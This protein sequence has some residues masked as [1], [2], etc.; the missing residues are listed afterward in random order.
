MEGSASG[1]W[2]AA[3]WNRTMLP[4]LTFAVTRCVISLAVKFFQ[5]RL[6]ALHRVRVIIYYC[7]SKSYD[8]SISISFFKRFIREISREAILFFC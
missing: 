6:S 4:G 8:H 2:S 1:V 5:S 3:L 7:I